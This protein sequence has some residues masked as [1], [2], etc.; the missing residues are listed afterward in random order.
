MNGFILVV[1][2]LVR[3]LF[4]V[5]GGIRSRFFLYSAVVVLWGFIARRVYFTHNHALNRE[6]KTQTKKESNYSPPLFFDTN[7]LITMRLDYRNR[8][9]QHGR[10]VLR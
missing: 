7:L 3:F 1:F 9:H 6:Q 8:K 5:D 4:P 2:H 10:A